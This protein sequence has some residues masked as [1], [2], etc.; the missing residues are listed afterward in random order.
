MGN[1]AIVIMALLVGVLVQC[2][3]QDGGSEEVVSGNEVESVEST[4]EASYTPEMFTIEAAENLYEIEWPT[5]NEI[6][7]N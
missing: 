1:L 7:Y 3:N 5:S 4:E 6:T 2:G